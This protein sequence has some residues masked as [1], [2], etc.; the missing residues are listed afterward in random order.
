LGQKNRKE[1]LGGNWD[2]KGNELGKL[3]LVTDRG[4]GAGGAWQVI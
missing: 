4:F 2:K 1:T 3:F